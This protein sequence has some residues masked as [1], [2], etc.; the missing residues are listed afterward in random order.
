[1]L[2]TLIAVIIGMAAGFQNI[3]EADDVGF[4]VDVR[5]GDAVAH[6]GLGSE[7]D[8]DIRSVI[9]KDLIDDGSVSNA[10]FDEGPIRI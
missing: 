2:H 4:Y 5:V 1:M 3:V 9:L 10:A 7:V 8:H 6:P